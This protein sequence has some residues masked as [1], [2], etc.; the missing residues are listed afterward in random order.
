M[1]ISEGNFSMR[2]KDK[3]QIYPKFLVLY[4][5][6]SNSACVAREGG[7]TRGTFYPEI[8]PKAV[9]YKDK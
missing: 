2:K 1:I 9:Y 4:E 5:Q 7:I 6:N 3:V 8:T